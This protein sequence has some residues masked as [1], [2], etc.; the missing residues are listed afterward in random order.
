MEIINLFITKEKCYQGKYNKKN[1]N[2]LKKLKIHSMN[3]FN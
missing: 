1:K 2:Q 3:K